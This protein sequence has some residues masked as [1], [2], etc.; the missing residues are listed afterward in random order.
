LRQGGFRSQSVKVLADVAENDVE[1]SEEKHGADAKENAEVFPAHVFVVSDQFGSPV[2]VPVAQL[3]RLLGNA[4]RL[5]RLH[6]QVDLRRHGH[7]F[8]FFSYAN[9][10]AQ[11]VVLNQKLSFLFA[12]LS[13]VG[14][15]QSV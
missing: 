7:I 9:S 10:L 1:E 5:I 4:H 2:N 3:Y 8:R 11:G 13:A 12:Q 6:R 14:S 15:L